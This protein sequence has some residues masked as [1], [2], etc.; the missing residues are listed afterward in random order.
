MLRAAVGHSE[1]PSPP[2][3]AHVAGPHVP[4]DP[5]GRPPTSLRPP[6]ALRLRAGWARAAPDSGRAMWVEG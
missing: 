3:S 6:Q 5:R 2:F 4:R 1:G